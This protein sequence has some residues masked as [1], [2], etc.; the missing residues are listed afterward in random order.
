MLTPTKGLHRDNSP[1]NQPP[2]TLRY[3]LNANLNKLDNEYVNE[4]GFELFRD[5]VDNLIIGKCVL[6]NDT[7]VLFSVSADGLTSQIGVIN[8]AGNYRIIINSTYLDF[9]AFNLIEAVYKINSKGEQLIYWTD[10]LNRLRYLNVFNHTLDLNANF[11]FNT[12]SDVEKLNAFRDVA[13]PTITPTSVDN[14]GG[15]IDA[16]VYYFAV[17]YV[18]AQGNET[19]YNAVSQPVPIYR[20]PHPISTFPNDFEGSNNVVTIKSINLQIATTDSRFEFMRIAV[21]PKVNNVVLAPRVFLTIPV[22]ASTQTFRYT[23]TETYTELTLDDVVIPKAFYNTCK[24]LAYHQKRLYIGNLTEPELPNL[25]RYVNNVIVDY[26]LETIDPV[27]YT[28]AGVS[29]EDSY[30]NEYR[31]ALKKGFLHDEVYALYMSFI[32]D[33]GLETNAFHIPGRPAALIP[34]TAKFETEEIDTWASSLVNVTEALQVNATGKYFQFGNTAG[35]SNATNIYS[36]GLSSNMGYWQNTNETY[37]NTDD[38]DVVDENGTV[39]Y[40]N[41]N[42]LVRHHKMPTLNTTSFK[43]GADRELKVAFLK[44]KNLRLPASVRANIQGFKVY[45]AKRNYNNATVIANGIMSPKFLLTVSAVNALQDFNTGINLNFAPGGTWTTTARTKVFSMNDFS[46]LNSEIDTSTVSHIKTHLKYSVTLVN[47]TGSG[48]FGPVSNVATYAAGGAP[49][50]GAYTADYTSLLPTD[51]SEQTKLNAVLT[52]KLENYNTPNPGNFASSA[53][54]VN[55]NYYGTTRSQNNFSGDFHII[56]ETVNNLSATFSTGTLVGVTDFDTDGTLLNPHKI[57]NQG[58]VYLYSYKEDVYQ[59]FD[60]QELEDT[61]TYVEITS[62]S[63]SSGKIQGDIYTGIYG[64]RTFCSYPASAT[65]FDISAYTVLHIVPHQSLSNFLLRETGT[66]PRDLFYPHSPQVD[67]LGIGTAYADYYGYNTT[68]SS[69]QDIRTAPIQPK[70]FTTTPTSKFT[71]R[72]HRS[73]IDNPES[74]QDNLLIF[75]PTEYKDVGLGRGELIVIKQ[76]PDKI[77]LHFEQGLYKTIGIDSIKTS[78]TEAFLGQADIFSVDPKEIIFT[79]LGYAGTQ[80]QFAGVITPYGYFFPDAKN[81]KVF[82]ITDTITEISGQGLFRWFNTYLPFKF[83]NQIQEL[84]ESIGYPEWSASSGYIP[85]D[86]VRRNA[87]YYQV[88]SGFPFT[89]TTPPEDDPA[90]WELIYAYTE[91]LKTDNTV[92]NGQVGMMSTYDQQSNRI[93]ITKKDFTIDPARFVGFYRITILTVILFNEGD[94]FLKDGKLYYVTSEP[95]SQ[96]GDFVSPFI[97]GTARLL[98]PDLED[99]SVDNSYTIS[100]YPE[101]KCWGSWYSYYPD[102]I[103]STQQNTYS[104]KLYKLFKHNIPSNTGLYYTATKQKTIYEYVSNT[105]QGEITVLSAFSF[106]TKT[107]NSSGIVLPLDTFNRAYLYNTYQIANEVIITNLSTARN[108]EGVWA[109]NQFRDS[110]DQTTPIVDQINNLN[111]NT[112][113]ISNTVPWKQRSKL[114]DNFHIIRLEYDNNNSYKH[115]LQKVGA[116]MRLSPR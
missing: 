15:Q 49:L 92:V 109:V 3:A 18:D 8:E 72:V 99:F 67:V 41:R 81:G 61:G 47:K 44:L 14:F 19:S 51:I 56:F 42:S 85:G 110:Y 104:T 53:L 27:P 73:A 32:T 26:E 58:Y 70:L 20:D 83:L 55:S 23:G 107:I 50:I 69:L 77:I 40:T 46:I 37:P 100:Y 5:F 34:T 17:A 2:E 82:L 86:I 45:A 90:N 89:S 62:S 79:D 6:N 33:E 38:W 4:D 88:I 78:S 108:S 103:Y 36:S 91:P 105:P 22:V 13:Y 11:E 43:D 9:S 75:S 94:I 48:V 97:G 93:I 111:I 106:I 115:T 7:T 24:T 76:T 98:P 68:Y 16:G 21:I 10:N 101:Q 84:I 57:S 59:S 30:Y 102:F 65:N 80:N 66:G 29:V 39:V 116:S 52:C 114:R 25:Q 95:V 1:I 112:S 64:Y 12:P 28:N 54:V 60:S 71:N 31:I 96:F 87:D 63:T 35:N 113:A 74:Q